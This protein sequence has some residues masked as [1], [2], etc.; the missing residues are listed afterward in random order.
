VS[1]GYGSREETIRQIRT[2]RDLA[3]ANGVDLSDAI[4]TITVA[5]LQAY[6]YTFETNE[7]T[8]SF[9]YLVPPEGVDEVTSIRF[10]GDTQH[11]ETFERMVDS[12][13]F[14]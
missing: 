13:E 3:E 4:R 1:V 9:V 11:I 12:F 14:V 8:I 10:R 2:D 7:E 5:G 6:A